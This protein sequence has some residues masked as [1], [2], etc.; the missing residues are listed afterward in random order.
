MKAIKLTCIFILGL[1]LLGVHPPCV[2]QNSRDLGNNAALQYLSAFL[3]LEDADLQEADVKELSGIVAG[4]QAY[5]EAKFGKLVEKNTTAIETMIVGSRLEPCDWGLA[6]RGHGPE[7]PVTYFWRARALG[8]LDLLYVLRAFSRGDQD[9]AV[10]ALAAGIR[11]SRHVPSGG[12]LVPA[13]LAKALLLQQLSIANRLL[14]SGKL[15]ASQRETLRTAVVS[16]GSEA[17]DWQAAM[18]VEMG[19]LK[20]AL[21]EERAASDPRQYYKRIMGRDAPSSFHGVTP[22]DYAAVER[23]SAAFVR[24]LKDAD[25]A[26][27]HQAVDAATPIVREWIPNPDRVVAAKQELKSALEETGKRLEK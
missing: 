10:R 21:D 25:A 1:V 2:A 17:V 4:T 6:Q 24:M 22:E 23:I 14:D 9:E 3:Q 12:P 19:G 8:R 27:V 20:T 5:D 7:T 26:P 16:L 15:N 18:R 13:V 11:F